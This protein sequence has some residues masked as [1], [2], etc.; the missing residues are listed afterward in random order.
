[1]MA[2]LVAAI[3][4]ALCVHR[5]RSDTQGGLFPLGSTAAIQCG[6]K[7]VIADIA[8]CTFGLPLGSFPDLVANPACNTSEG[9][10]AV[11]SACLSKSSCSLTVAEETFAPASFSC[12]NP[13]GR[14][15]SLALVVTCLPMRPV[16]RRPLPIRSRTLI[17]NSDHVALSAV[18]NGDLTY[19]RE[20]NSRQGD[21]V[22]A[23]LMAAAV[24]AA[25]A[26]VVWLVH[27]AVGH[28]TRLKNDARLRQTSSSTASG[29]DSTSDA[30][31]PRISVTDSSSP[32]DSL[33]TGTRT[34]TISGL[35]SAS[36][37][38]SPRISVTDS[39]HAKD[40][41]SIGTRMFADDVDWTHNRQRTMSVE[42]AARPGSLS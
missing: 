42:F 15:M 14:P 31:S 27:I 39:V 19:R 17:Y 12:E 7:S 9:L 23:A 36:S 30:T 20:S 41:L 24:V 28:V 21:P 32:K 22:R 10:Q 8:V 5:V 18:S 3:V 13:A 25:V 40:S 6:P 29:V 4:A 34:S 26:V 1:M 35:D 33:P 16:R 38:S 37:A 11:R 2:S